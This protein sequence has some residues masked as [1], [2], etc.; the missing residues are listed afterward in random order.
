MAVELRLAPA[1]EREILGHYG[2]TVE[3]KRVLDA[4]LRALCTRSPVAAK[5]WEQACA[6]YYAWRAQQR[7]G[8]R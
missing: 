1:K 2:L 6:V 7:G 3:G 4:E 8:R 5:E